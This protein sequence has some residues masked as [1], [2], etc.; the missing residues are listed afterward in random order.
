LNLYQQSLLAARKQLALSKGAAN[1][2]R[3]SLAIPPLR[4]FL[5]NLSL[6]V[7]DMLRLCLCMFVQL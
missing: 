4:M 3:D 5:I 1:R 2:E 7:V 6:V